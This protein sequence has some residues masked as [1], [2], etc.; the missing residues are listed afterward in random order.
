MIPHRGYRRILDRRLP[1]V[2]L[3][4]LHHALTPTR[5]SWL[6]SSVMWALLGALLLLLLPRGRYKELR[7]SIGVRPSARSLLCGHQSLFSRVLACLRPAWEKA[8]GH[9]RDAATRRVLSRALARQAR[10]ASAIAVPAF[11]PD[12]WL[13]GKVLAK[14]TAAVVCLGRDAQASKPVV[15]PPIII[16]VSGGYLH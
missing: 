15:R 1:G 13:S 5:Y 4:D 2:V 8:S 7:D 6:V 9:S 10:V 3:G 11:R 14:G 12:S 16:L